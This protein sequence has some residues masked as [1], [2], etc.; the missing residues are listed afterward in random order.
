[1]LSG[2]STQVYRYGLLEPTNNAELV[3]EQMLLAHRYRN[4]LV[5]I[6]RG[7][8]AATRTATGNH[9]L[10][11]AWLTTIAEEA[12]QS[13]AEAAKRIKSAKADTRSREVP[14]DLQDSYAAAKAARRE[15]TTRLHVGRAWVKEDS[16]V[17]ARLAEIKMI[18]NELQKNARAHCGVYWGTYLLI[19]D[20]W[21]AAA[22]MPLFD[23]AEATDPRFVRWSGEGAVG[24]Q[25]QKGEDASA[26]IDGD[27]T[28]LRIVTTP[29]SRQEGK[30]AQFRQAPDPT[31]KRSLRRAGRER[32]LWMRIGS[33]G[34]SPIWAHWPLILHR[35]L[36]EL[37]RVKRASVIRRMIGPRAEWSLQI[38]V[39]IPD[40]M[41]ARKH[42]GA[43]AVDLG[44]RVIGDEIRVAVWRGEDGGT[45]EVRLSAN[46]VQA[47]RIPEGLAATRTTSFSREIAWLAAWLADPARR[48]DGRDS[49]PLWVV[50]A[51]RTLS[52]WRSI[53]RLA[54]LVHRWRDERFVGD[55]E[56]FERLEAWR[57]QD[58]HLWLWESSQRTGGHRRR[59]DVYRRMAA[60]LAERYDVLVLETFDLRDVSQRNELGKLRG[61]NDA[62]QSNRHLAAP[63]WLR[64]CLKQAFA[65][66]GGRHEK[67]DGAYSTH[68]CP[69][70]GLVAKFDAAPMISWA[71]ACGA[72]HD[73]DESAAR[74][75]LTRWIERRDSAQVAGVARGGESVNEVAQLKESRWARAK[76]LSAEKKA[77]AAGAREV[78]A[79]GSESRAL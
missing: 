22:K 52:Q 31:S 16:S 36:P 25:I 63:G 48:V 66:R 21:Q 15:A 17:Q 42:A 78:D 37:G 50:A 56:A 43:V 57:R 79:K 59:N 13:V 69:M 41:P 8:R 68:T 20:E 39:E 30:R 2:M 76:R 70:C 19:E 18:A 33:D 73:Q 11:I 72:I 64:T 7:K 4:T 10:A 9:E 26:L 35:P 6:E 29:I 44:W 67:V 61:D 5:E 51:T 23:G 74:V 3:E 38:T 54:S 75:L 62:A 53:G 77:A 47:I 12:D 14:R 45:G 49:T 32:E 71:C 60:E 28:R 58:R 1:M 40:P 34:Q 55:A 27:D 24:V 46:D 65:A